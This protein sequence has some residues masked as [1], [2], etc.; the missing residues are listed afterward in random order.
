MKILTSLDSLIH[1]YSE[2]KANSSYSMHQK[3]CPTQIG[4]L[5]PK[6]PEQLSDH[7]KGVIDAYRALEWGYRRIF[8]Q[9]GRGRTTIRAYIR[10]NRRDRREVVDHA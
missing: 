7:E 5:I 8:R 1:F 9:I 4:A 2:T 3:F 10:R 6:M